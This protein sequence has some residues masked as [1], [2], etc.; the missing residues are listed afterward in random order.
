M[1]L[2]KLASIIGVAFLALTALAIWL[3]QSAPP[4]PI[5]HVVTVQPGLTD[6]RGLEMQLVT[7]AFASSNYM[8][9]K[10]NGR[11]AEAKIGGVWRK[12]E[13]PWIDGAM[14]PLELSPPNEREWFLHVPTGSC[15]CQVPLLYTGPAWSLKRSALSL[16]VGAPKSIRSKLPF[17]FWRWAYSHPSPSSHWHKMNIEFQL[18]AEIPTPRN[19]L[20][21]SSSRE[22]G[23]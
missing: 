8:W 9:I 7:V 12:V 21:E 3:P 14:E 22:Q 15:A 18:S 10:D 6:D 2:R 13:H 11:P 4:A 5:T 16:A 1:R 23:P 20:T 17:S 19:V